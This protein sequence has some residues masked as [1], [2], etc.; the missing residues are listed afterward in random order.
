M[1]EG[2]A[3][4]SAGKLGLETEDF[5]RI[6]NGQ[7]KTYKD[8]RNSYRLIQ[9]GTVVLRKLGIEKKKFR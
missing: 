2:P 4:I 7:N 3:P 5:D 9:F 1:R 6:I 8:Y